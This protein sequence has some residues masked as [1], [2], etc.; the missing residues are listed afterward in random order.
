MTD[1]CDVAIVG[2][3]AMGASAAAHCAARG[4]SVIGIDRYGPLHD[5]GSSHGDTRIIRLAY[6]E[7]PAYV[8]LLRRAYR[9]WRDLETWCGETLLTI[10]GALE[11]GSPYGEVVSGVMRSVREHGLRVET[12]TAPEAMQR[13]PAFRLDRDE[14]AVLE[15]EG[16]FLRPERCLA[17]ALKK[18]GAHGARLHFNERV[19][20]L[21]ADGHGITVVTTEGRY[22]ARKVVLAMGSW[23]A[24]LVPELE[25]IVRPI[26]QV[27]GWFAAAEPADAA[28]MP[29]FIGQDPDGWSFFGFPA[30][31]PAGIKLG[32]HGHRDEA[33]DPEGRD[34]PVD[35]TDGAI[36]SD[37]VRRRLPEAKP[38]QMTSAI[39][40][41]YTMLPEGFFLIDRSP[42]DTRIL[43]ASPCS[44]H[45]FKFASVVGEALADL[46]QRDETSL[47]IAPFS[48]E[49]MRTRLGKSSTTAPG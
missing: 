31:G 28:R 27:V 22:R 43:V 15:P 37:F 8:P 42:A 48:F 41:R 47:P 46:V 5:R 6:F 14:V 2:L 23:V 13:F 33:I 10:T 38:N 32:R 18:A 26:R 45:G 39:T 40:C 35:A 1:T 3:G 12:M 36:L 29:V 11:F 9:N 25:G 19:E 49:A 30:L 20:T 21:D 16:G 4:L 7:D 34:R 44:G 24:S 17:A